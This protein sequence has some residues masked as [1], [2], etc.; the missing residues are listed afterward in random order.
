MSV[1]GLPPD[2]VASGLA[3]LLMGRLLVSTVLA[4]SEDGTRP[5][6]FVVGR[7]PLASQHERW[8]NLGADS[9]ASALFERHDADPSDTLDGVRRFLVAPILER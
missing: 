3:C 6:V 1:V 9:I 2:E 7:R 4:A 5:T 8:T